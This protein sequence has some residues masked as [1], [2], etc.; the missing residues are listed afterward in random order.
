MPHRSRVAQVTSCCH[1]HLSLLPPSVFLSRLSFRPVSN[2]LNE[3]P[4][5]YCSTGD[6]QVLQREL[7]GS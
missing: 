7:A 4:Y 2:S 5:C 1:H 6:E 3:N